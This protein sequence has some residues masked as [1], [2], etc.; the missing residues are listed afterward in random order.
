[1]FDEN[2]KRDIDALIDIYKKESFSSITDIIE[3]ITLLF[4]LKIID[5]KENN[6][7]AESNFFGRE[8]KSFYLEKEEL[9]RWCKIINKEPEVID[10]ILI[11]KISEVYKDKYSDEYEQ[12]ITYI[13]SMQYKKFSNL[14]LLTRVLE[15]VELLF[16]KYSFNMGQPYDY[17]LNQIPPDKDTGVYITPRHIVKLII[18]LMKPSIRDSIMDICCGSGGFLVYAREY[19]LKNYNQELLDSN[20]LNHFKKTQFFGYE[21]DKH[22]SK[23]SAM[24]MCL[25]GAKHTNI[26]MIN[27]LKYHKELG[28][29]CSIAISNIPFNGNEDEDKISTELLKRTGSK[30]RQLLFINQLIDSLK[31]GGRCAVIVSDGFL[32]GS[33]KAYI[34]VK[35]KI[36]DNNK[37]EAIISMPSGIF[38]I[39]SK[40]G[41]KS[42][43]STAIMI[44]TKTGSGGTDKVWFYDMK[45]DGYS[46]D[47][48]RNPIDKNDI[49][50]II[51][52]FNN[53]DKE[54]DRKRTEQSFFVQLDEIHK[55]K[56]D[57]SMN[58]YIKIVSE[59]VKYRNSKI[60]LENIKNLEKE[61]AKGIEN[62]EQIVEVK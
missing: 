51:E 32:F 28:E 56:Y 1:M 60:I 2:I 10:D 39:K 6:K 14:A 21:S 16:E 45:A 50:D 4:C 18:E 44:F 31:I 43:V 59:E 33:K 3:Q 29:R 12:Y 30:N 25:H 52:R 36:I 5:L 17:L 7:E 15:K 9:F 58:K 53:L 35:E 57:L 47:D 34:K 20:N 22:L 54:M 24:N 13:N 61:I 41:K 23:F 38:K 55:N 26:E 49:P 37:L 42:G 62:L 8:F 19:I 46:L 11:N 27:T 40:S 48:K